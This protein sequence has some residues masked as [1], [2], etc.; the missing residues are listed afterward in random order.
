MTEVNFTDSDISA[1]LKGLVELGGVYVVDD[2]PDK[3]IRIKSTNEISTTN[4]DG[5][6][7]PMA[8]YGT[9]SSDCII[10][11]PFVEGEVDSARNKWFYSTKN[12]ELSAFLVAILKHLLEQGADSKK[13]KK[14][15]S[16]KSTDLLAV[17]LL[18]DVVTDIDEKMLKEF[19]TITNELSNFFNIYWNKSLNQC[20]VK[21]SIYITAQRKAFGQSIR[22][23]TWE[24]LETLMNKVLGTKDLGEFT[25]KPTTLGVPVFETFVGILLEIYGRILEPL[26]MIGHELTTNIECLKS[27]LKY[28]GHY[29][30]KAKWCI[31]PQPM[32]Q[33]VP[34]QLPWNNPMGMSG[35]PMISNNIP[36][37]TSPVV[38]TYN[39]NIGTMGAP[40][41]APMGYT[42]MGAPMGAPMC[43]PMVD[44]AGVPLMS[45]QPQAPGMPNPMQQQ[46]MMSLPRKDNPFSKP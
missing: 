46:Q 19:K 16:D 15:D 25:R 32:T 4:V 12:T 8:L 36:M 26:K 3:Y 10:I 39:F 5:I 17:S 38:P 2:S 41:G 24:V 23:K 11:N 43:G 28:V 31:G 22:V 34:A 45:I 20:E 1:F 6:M 7:K 18:E 37:P 21:C 27:H 42:P 13:K 40:M 30:S 14:D 29:A 35:V 9:K 33:Q 44:N